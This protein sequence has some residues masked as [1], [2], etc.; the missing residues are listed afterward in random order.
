MSQGE[1]GTALHAPLQTY[2]DP[3]CNRTHN[4]L[5]ADLNSGPSQIVGR[6]GPCA[7]A[8]RAPVSAV[9]ALSGRAPS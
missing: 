5:R 8:S 6:D 7:S 2:G 1:A 3:D 9:A 4:R